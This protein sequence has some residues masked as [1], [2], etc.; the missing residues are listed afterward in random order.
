[1]V[2]PAQTDDP[3][4]SSPTLGGDVGEEDSFDVRALEKGDGGVGRN[5]IQIPLQGPPV[6]GLDWYPSDVDAFSIQGNG[7]HW[8]LWS[9]EV[10]SRY[11]W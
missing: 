3:F 6:D 1:M 5:G 4:Y 11:D 9:L 8:A 10:S 2:F 7:L